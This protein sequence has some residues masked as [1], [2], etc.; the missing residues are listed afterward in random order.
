MA[1]GIMAQISSDGEPVIRG[2]L[3]Q[4]AQEW[5][6]LV[7]KDGPPC[8]ITLPTDDEVAAQQENMETWGAGV[9]LKA[10]VLESLGGAEGGDWEGW[11]T[12]EDY[13]QL[14]EKLVL[15]K[16]QFIEYLAK[17][18]KEQEAWERA[19]PFRDD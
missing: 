3:F 11:S 5:E 9:Q 12:H 7:G 8:P 2:L 15:V 17:T 14:K 16:E 1:I 6:K 4:A 19:W 10:D 13:D 18:P